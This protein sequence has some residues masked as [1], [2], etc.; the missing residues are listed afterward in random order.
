MD[1][2]R[3]QRVLSSAA[4]LVRVRRRVDQRRRTKHVD[5]LHDGVP[6]H[7]GKGFDYLRRRFRTVPQNVEDLATRRIRQ[8]FPDDVVVVFQFESSIP[9]E[10]FLTRT[11]LE[12]I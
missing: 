3:V 5:V 9:G 11:G 4:I 10:F 2:D 8:S 12:R 1:R 6:C 7:I